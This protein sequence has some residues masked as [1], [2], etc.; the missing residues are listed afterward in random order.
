MATTDSRTAGVLPPLS[1]EGA[2][3]PEDAIRQWVSQITGIPITLVRK[4]WLAKPGTKPALSQDWCAVG[5]EK[6]RTH[7]TPYQRGKKGIISDPESG[8]VKRESHQTL[9]CIAS[10]YGPSA[11]ELSDLF[12][13][14]SQIGQNADALAASGMVVQGVDDD[15]VHLPDFFHEQWV[16][17]YDVSFRLGRKVVHTFGVRD[18]AKIGDLEI[19]TEKREGLN[20]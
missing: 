5:V 12:R 19:Y 15:I 20:A 9:H 14:S 4:R 11:A 3:A 10:F 16:D 17:R 18:L 6:I 1:T 8:D 7:G 13:E 2:L